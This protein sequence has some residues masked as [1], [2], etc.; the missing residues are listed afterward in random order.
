ML[1]RPFISTRQ[2]HSR[3]CHSVDV[4]LFWTILCKPQRWFCMK[5]TVDKQFLKYMDQPIWY[6]Q[7]CRVQIYINP[8]YFLFGFSQLY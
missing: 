2:F 7:P 4:L 8:F 6:Q 3:N 1:L 5:I